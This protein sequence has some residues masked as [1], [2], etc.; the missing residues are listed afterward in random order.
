MT[1]PDLGQLA[2]IEP[3][4]PG[5][6]ELNLG[7]QWRAVFIDPDEAPEGVPMTYGYLL[8]FMAGKAYVV[9]PRGSEDHWSTVEGAFT[10][11]EGLEAWAKR[12][13]KE[14]LNATVGKL[15]ILGLFECKA[16][17][18]NTEHPRGT[19]TLRPLGFVVLKKIDDLPR[20][21]A[22]ERR[23]LPTNEHI[24]LVRLRY[25]EFTKYFGDA[26]SEYQLL[27]AKGQG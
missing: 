14:Q 16:T 18:H 17:Q 19:R 9:R 22:W 6:T 12:E 3:P 24:T 8:A 5:V 27:L 10:A 23:R 2:M 21:S 15:Q 13:I 20:T 7:D 25:P 26:A 4:R 11:G 1:I